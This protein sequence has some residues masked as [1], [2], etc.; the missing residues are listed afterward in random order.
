MNKLGLI[1]MLTLGATLPLSPYCWCSPDLQYQPI[2]ETTE[3]SASPSKRQRRE[4]SPIAQLP[5]V[6]SSRILGYADRSSISNWARCSSRE[7][8]VIGAAAVSSIALR[9]RTDEARLSVPIEVDRYCRR[10]WTPN[11]YLTS[12][13][14]ATLLRVFL[15]N[16]KCQKVVT[17]VHFNSNM[18]ERVHR[19]DLRQLASKF[20]ISSLTFGQSGMRHIYNKS[21]GL[22]ACFLRALTP[23]LHLFPHLRQLR[24]RGPLQLSEHHES[25][26]VYAFL[27]EVGRLIELRHL[28]LIWMK[29]EDAF[30]RVIKV[31]ENLPELS[32]LH[33]E[34]PTFVNCP[35]SSQNAALLIDGLL[36]LRNLR[37]L[38]L[39]HLMVTEEARRIL[40]E[41][42]DFLVG[43][44]WMPHLIVGRAD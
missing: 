36:R 11:V 5:E 44:G 2:D 30:I 6:L 38:T 3:A 12:S 26:P 29:R 41:H 40:V 13:A 34:F 23:E 21:S 39:P 19:K 31:V 4:V 16:E 14:P 17:A 37:K 22:W 9:G 10:P 28:E 33:V 42:E 35:L 32:T 25:D 24:V 27:V 15:D 20:Q 8:K 18:L 1:W 43:L 7:I